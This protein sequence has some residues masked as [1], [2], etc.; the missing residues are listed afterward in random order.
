MPRSGAPVDVRAIRR[1]SSERITIH[2]RR[3]PDRLRTFDQRLVRRDPDCVITLL[4][5]A[6]FD[7][8]VEAAG[9]VILEPGAPVV[10]FTWRDRWHDVGRFHLADGTFT[11]LYANILTP[12]AG[13]DTN[14]WDTTD[15]FLDVWLPAGGGEPSLLDVDE[16]DQ[17]VNEGH[18]TDQVA[19]SAKA[20]AE[21]L[22]S[23][24]RSGSWPGPEVAAWPLERAISSSM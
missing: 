13:F 2:Y 3:P 9:S 7:Q 17:A 18:L 23:A 20:E 15:L 16:F 10:W 19:A 6:P 24:A 8:P 11:G 1:L 12:V 5:N 14:S 4:E 22:M 21:R